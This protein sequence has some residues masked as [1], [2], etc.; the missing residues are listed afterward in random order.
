MK[1]WY[2]KGA[3]MMNL[4]ANIGTAPNCIACSAVRP[5]PKFPLE[6]SARIAAPEM[7]N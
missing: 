7:Q 1:R 5:S 3:A 6:V 2:V 4:A